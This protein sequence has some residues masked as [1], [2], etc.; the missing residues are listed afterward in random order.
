M[1]MR[2]INIYIIPWLG[3][4]AAQIGIRLSFLE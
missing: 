2:M 3:Y 4:D 1:Q